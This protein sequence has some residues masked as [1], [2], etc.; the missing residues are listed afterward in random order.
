MSPAD[1]EHVIGGPGEQRAC[2]RPA[3]SWLRASDAPVSCSGDFKKF[4]HMS[5][6]TMSSSEELADQ[7]GSV[8][9]SAFEQGE[10]APDLGGGGAGGGLG[11]ALGLVLTCLHDTDHLSAPPADLNGTA[12]ELPVAVPSGPFRHTGLSK[13]ARTHRLR[14][15]RS[16]AKC[17]ECNSYV[18]FQ[19]AECEEVSGPRDAWGPQAPPVFRSCP[20]GR[21]LR[22]PEP[23]GA[24][25][26]AR[27]PPTPPPHSAAWPATRSA[28]RPWPSSAAT[29]SF[30]AA[31]SSSARTSA[32]RPAT[33]RTA[34]PSSS[35]SA[36]AR[37]SGGRC[38]PRCPRG[39]GRG[40]PRGVR[41]GGRG[42]G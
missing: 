33:P 2:R 3:R 42:R 6:G 35:R 27:S 14:K 29:R 7:E 30:R 19:G 36:S 40:Q 15:L 34:C 11:S 16:P 1:G 21:V 8:G 37:S 41:G 23:G 38:A 24:A 28:W 10:E 5:S 20:A 25:G 26:A 4:E 17:R 39:G 12:P 22:A 31:C 13:A 18:Y 9:T 32:R